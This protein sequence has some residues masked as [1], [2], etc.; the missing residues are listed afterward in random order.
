[1]LP[2]TELSEIRNVKFDLKIEL[3][4]DI[5]DA[6][7]LVPLQFGLKREWIIGVLAHVKDVLGHSDG[8]V[9]RLVQFVSYEEEV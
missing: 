6:T 5:Y 4:R 3:K 8:A 1:M 9:V 7:S 2:T